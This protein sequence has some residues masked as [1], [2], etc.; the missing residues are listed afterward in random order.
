MRFLWLWRI[1]NLFFLLL[2]VICFSSCQLS[3]PYRGQLPLPLNSQPR[4]IMQK[5]VPSEAKAITFRGQNK[6]ASFSPDGRFILYV[7][8]DRE[9]HKHSQIYEMDLSSKEER[10]LTFHDGE[11]RDPSYHPNGQEIIYASSTDELKEN[12]LFIREA[13]EKLK[14]DQNEKSARHVS[15]SQR[16]DK[17]LDRPPFEV[18]VSHR[19]GSHIQRLTNSPNFDAEA[20]YHPTGKFLVFS[21]MRTGH[22][23]VFT[24]APDGQRQ[25]L[26]SQGKH[27][28]D[29]A[30]FSRNGREIAWVRYSKTSSES[31]IYVAQ[32]G[33]GKERPLTTKKA[34]HWSPVWH[35]GNEHIIFSS[36]R[37]PNGGF[38]LYVM[39]SDGSCVNRLTY[40]SGDDQ[41]PEISPDGKKLLFTSHRNGSEQVYMMDFKI[42]T[43]CPESL[44]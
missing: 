24:M 6:Q 22:L 18:Y 12:P 15:F 35:P 31:Q 2:V 39:R 10:R 5:Y 29:E 41:D 27:L 20:R 42:P 4:R 21:T 32:A 23:K 40:S 8:R 14:K 43:T 13:V 9:S 34:H 3:H 33:R 11:N 16:V 25:Q 19:N 17:N 38:E 26:W 7:S 44:H 36:N 37:A 1:F 28:D 30:H